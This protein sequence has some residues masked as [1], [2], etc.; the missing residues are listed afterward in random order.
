MSPKQQRAEATVDRLLAAAL[1]VYAASGQQGFTV[2]AVT[3]ASGVSLGSLYH[4]FGSFDGLAAALYLRCMVQLCDAMSEALLRAR[5]ARTG[6]RALVAAYLRFTQEHPDVSLFIHASAYSGRAAAQPQEVRAADAARFAVV[7]DW[8]RPRVVA[9]EVAALPEPVIGVLVLGPV[10]ETA[11]RW[12]AGTFDVDLGQAARILPD[13]I[14]RSVQPD[15][16]GV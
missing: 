7:S 15:G 9:G 6:I 14:W 2:N 5:S 10:M 4:H 16:S 12:L 11:R 13:R 8:L 3:R 1:Q